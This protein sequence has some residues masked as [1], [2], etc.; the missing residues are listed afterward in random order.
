M[1]DPLSSFAHP[2]EKMNIMSENLQ[3][4]V[5]EL[6]NRRILVLGDVILDEYLFGKAE[7]LSREAPIPVLEY[8]SRRYIPGGAANPAANIVSLGSEAVQAT[9]V[10]NDDSADTLRT[11]LKE[12]GIDTSSLV[13]EAGKPTTLKTR[14][15]AQMGLRF[16]QQIARI[17][18]ISRKPIGQLIEA[19]L[20]SHIQRHLP[21]V[22][23]ILI[24][25]YQNGLL[26]SSVVNLVKQIAVGQNVPTVVDTQGALE[27][28]RGFDVI[29]CNSDDASAYLGRYLK[30]DDDYAEAAQ[31]LAETLAVKHAMVIT[32]GGDGATVAVNGG[33]EHAISPNVSDVFDTVGAGDTWIAVLTLGLVAGANVVE[34]AMLAN[35]ASGIVVRHVGNYAPSPEELLRALASN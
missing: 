11:Q 18:T 20:L 30:E 22:N 3:S 14:I 28:Y 10:G 8:Q 5:P 27:K 34:A 21:N 2:K 12:R 1:I 7:R 35:Y 25:D 16:P 26:T 4:L 23:A 32:R 13:I 9:V 19:A 15:M 6:A 33:I 24:S 17:D 31:E 29:K